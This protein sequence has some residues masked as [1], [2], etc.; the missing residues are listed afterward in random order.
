MTFRSMW[1]ASIVTVLCGVSPALATPI[2]SGAGVSYTS[3]LAGVP[4]T[5]TTVALNHVHPLWQQNN[6]DGSTAVWMS[7]AQTGNVD[8]TDIL[9]PFSGGVVTPVF[10]ILL[11]FNLATS[12]LLNLKIW[13]DDTARVNVDNG[14]LVMNPIAAQN[15][16]ADGP[17]GCEPNEA[18]II[19]N[20]FWA[21]GAHSILL[22][23]YQ[24]GSGATP[25]ANPFGALY[26]GS[27]EAAPVPEPASMVLLGT[28]LMGLAASLRRR[29]SPKS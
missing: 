12:S 22:D 21:A 20:F 16:C 25:A 28:G 26:Y 3:T 1:S 24:V 14:A 2:V 13:A 17:I 6:P 10:S 18:G 5:G 9:A 8:A 29:R 27:V 23:F 4:A 7:Y 15:V 19:T 11:N